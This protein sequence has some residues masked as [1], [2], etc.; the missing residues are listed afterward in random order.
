MYRGVEVGIC[1]GVRGEYM[2]GGMCEDDEELDWSASWASNKA[3]IIFLFTL[4]CMLVFFINLSSTATWFPKE[5][6]ASGG[7]GLKQTPAVT[8]S[9]FVAQ[10]C[11]S[12]F[13]RLSAGLGVGKME[14]WS[15]PSCWVE[16]SGPMVEIKD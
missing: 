10:L 14:L 11:V 12:A 16:G 7:A 8:A 6:H 13:R 4:V 2:G 5:L 3:F 1:V 9:V 15:S